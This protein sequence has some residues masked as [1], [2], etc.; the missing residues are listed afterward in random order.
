MAHHNAG[1]CQLAN[2]HP[3]ASNL[4]HLGE[5]HIGLIVAPQ[6]PEHIDRLKTLKRQM[7][8]RAN[9]Y[10]LELRFLLAA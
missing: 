5:V 9:L 1:L 4:H 8:G 6:A 2:G 3:G 10:L 7:Y